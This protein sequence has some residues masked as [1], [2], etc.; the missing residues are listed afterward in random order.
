MKNIEKKLLTYFGKENQSL[1][2]SMMLY[3]FTNDEFNEATNLNLINHDNDNIVY[4]IAKT[5]L[6]K[7]L[8]LNEFDVKEIDK[9]SQSEIDQI[10]IDILDEML[11]GELSHKHDF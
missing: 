1:I 10:S 8:L 3:G 2:G 5:E 4:F 9:F 11:V 7:S 6:Q